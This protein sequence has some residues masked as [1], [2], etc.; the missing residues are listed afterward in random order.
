MMKMEGDRET[1]GRRMLGVGGRRW[2]NEKR[3]RNGEK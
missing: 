3:N 1:E 2:G